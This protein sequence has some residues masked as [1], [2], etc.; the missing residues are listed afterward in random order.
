MACP[1][2]SRQRVRVWAWTPPAPLMTSTAQSS[3]PSTRSISA[4][5]STCPGVSS[6]VRAVSPQVSSACLAKMVMP[7][8]R[9]W[10]SVSRKAS[11][12]STRPSLLTEPLRYKNPSD[13]VVLP[14]S[15][16][17]SSPVQMC[18]AGSRSEPMAVTSRCQNFRNAGRGAKLLS[19]APLSR[20]SAVD[21]H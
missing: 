18:L 16:W 11:R 20:D 9:S 14:A 4:E 17:A 10:A 21:I 1:S 5:K 12:W 19:F 6:R 2:S 15:T 13:R 8:S 3:T 7:R